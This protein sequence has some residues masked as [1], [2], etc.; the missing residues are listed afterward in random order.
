[1]GDRRMV[2]VRLDTLP[3]PLRRRLSGREN[4]LDILRG[5]FRH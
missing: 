4:I 5:K 2:D 1:V 3:L